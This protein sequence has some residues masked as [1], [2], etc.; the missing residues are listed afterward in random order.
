[1]FIGRYP[2]QGELPQVAERATAFGTYLDAIVAA[3]NAQNKKKTKTKNKNNK[4]KKKQAIPTNIN[5]SSCL[6]L[7]SY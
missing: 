7:T 2:L 1:M 6:K 5:P 3:A 4:N